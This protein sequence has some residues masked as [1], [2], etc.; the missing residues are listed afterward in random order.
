MSALFSAQN[1]PT[2]DPKITIVSMHNGILNFY[3]MYNYI[4]QGPRMHRFCELPTYP[5]SE[6]C[7]SSCI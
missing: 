5:E 3:A 2:H 6:S 4:C 7:Q 1:L